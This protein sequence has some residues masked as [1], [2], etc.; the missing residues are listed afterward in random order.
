MKI[1][2]ILLI[3]FLS[4]P[5][6][7]GN[8]NIEIKAKKESPKLEANTLLRATFTDEVEKLAASITSKNR[9]IIIDANFNKVREEPVDH[10]ENLS[11]QSMLVPI[12]Y[13][14]QFITKIYNV[15][16]YMLQKD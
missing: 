15:S 3:L 1:I 16:Y 10:I 9:V 5:T 6:F 12:I 8:P 14:S 7:A 4:L 11:N 13:R 2:G